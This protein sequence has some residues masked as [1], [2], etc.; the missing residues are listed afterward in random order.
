V[1]GLKQC[2]DCGT[3]NRRRAT[4]RYGTKEKWS[5]GRGGVLLPEAEEEDDDNNG[6]TARDGRFP[7]A[8][9]AAVRDNADNLEEE[10]D[11]SDD[12]I[13]MERLG[14]PGSP[15]GAGLDDV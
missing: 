7:A 6:G 14:L 3:T 12:D 10:G 4:R 11:D 1:A 5:D 9:A 2:T 8:T 15:T 13:P